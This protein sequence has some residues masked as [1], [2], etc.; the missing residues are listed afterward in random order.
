MGDARTYIYLDGEI[1]AAAPQRLSQALSKVQ[2]GAI[3]ISFNSPGGN[4]FAGMELGR[5]I[6]KYGASTDIA[7]RGSKEF[8]DQPGVCFSAC[9]LAYLGGSFRYAHKGSAYGVHRVSSASGPKVTDLDVGQI[10]SAT[11]VSYLREMGADPG[12]FDLMVKAGADNIYLL[13]AQEAKDLHVVNNGRMPPVWS[14]EVIPGGMYLRGVQ[15]TLY[16]LGKAIFSCDQGKLVF[17]SVYE[18]GEKARLIADGGWVHKLMIDGDDLPLPAPFRLAN[19]NGFVNAMFALTAPQFR[20]VMSAKQIGHGM[21]ISR[22][23]PTFVGYHVDIDGKSAPR[24]RDFIGN[25][26]QIK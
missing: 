2:R 7:M 23:A 11:I 17:Y 16:G 1:D 24:V 21:Q 9:S 8:Q 18:A 19:E 22:E 12:L 6:R 13:S 15:V 20:R 4:L 25:C 26:V 5:I 3:F 10:L 14:I